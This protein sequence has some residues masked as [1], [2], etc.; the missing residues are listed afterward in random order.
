[1]YPLIRLAG[2]VAFS[3]VAELKSPY[4]LT[5]AVTYRCQLECIMCGIWRKP[6]SPELGADEIAEFFSIN[7]GFSW[8]KIGRAS[9][10][11]RV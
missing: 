5:F 9:C 10:R 4:R 2:N 1:M 8:I 6:P 3:N 11:E 7:R